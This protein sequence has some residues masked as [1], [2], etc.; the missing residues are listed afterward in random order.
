MFKVNIRINTD[1]DFSYN[2]TEFGL[3]DF[4]DE[5]TFYFENREDALNAL[6]RSYHSLRE[7]LKDCTFTEISRWVAKIDDRLELLCKEFYTFGINKS[8]GNYDINYELIET[9]K[10][11]MDNGSYAYKD[12]LSEF[13]LAWFID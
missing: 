1:G 9:E 7:S 10:I 8:F 13:N 5:Q 11:N 12:K 6:I 4:D 3:K 2:E